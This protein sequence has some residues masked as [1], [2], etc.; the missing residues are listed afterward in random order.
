[1]EILLFPP[2]TLITA[3]CDASFGWFFKKKELLTHG[4]NSQTGSI[5]LQMRDGG[6]T[7][8]CVVSTYNRNRA[9]AY[10]IK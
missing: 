2:T 1:M 8:I 7:D 4:N 5:H 3:I 9:V 6:S 10:L